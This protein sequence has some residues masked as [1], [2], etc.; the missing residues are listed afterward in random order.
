MCPHKEKSYGVRSGDLASYFIEGESA[1]PARPVQRFSRRSYRCVRRR[2]ATLLEE[3][4][5]AP[6]TRYIKLYFLKFIPY[7]TFLKVFISFVKTLYIDCYHP[8]SN[9]SNYIWRNAISYIIPFL[10]SLHLSPNIVPCTLVLSIFSTMF[11]PL[12]DRPGFTST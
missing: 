1:C 7:H 12:V 3:T 4:S 8:S 10:F 9:R 2:C 6:L 5:T 11:F